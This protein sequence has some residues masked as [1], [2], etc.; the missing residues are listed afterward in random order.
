MQSK[1]EV[2]VLVREILQEKIQKERSGRQSDGVGQT[3]LVVPS[4]ARLLVVCQDEYGL[5]VT[6]RRIH[7]WFR[8][9]NPLSRPYFT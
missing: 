2:H 3:E 1:S 6:G 8:L 5:D 9:Q 7:F 4:L